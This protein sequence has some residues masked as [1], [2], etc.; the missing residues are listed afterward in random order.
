MT[1]CSSKHLFTPKEN[2]LPIINQSPLP[3]P[4]APGPSNLLSVSK[5][6]FLLDIS[7]KWNPVTCDLL[8]LAPFAKL[9]VFE[10]HPLCGMYQIFFYS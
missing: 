6:L 9:H 8:Q 1:L 5:D 3:P 7:Y 4:L 10:I 2:P